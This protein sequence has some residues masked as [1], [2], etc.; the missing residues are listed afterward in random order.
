MMSAMSRR[1]WIILTF[2]LLLA[3]ASGFAWGFLTHSERVFP[4]PV[5]SAAWQGL[6]SQPAV[7]QALRPVQRGQPSAAEH[8]GRFR[9]PHADRSAPPKPGGRE[10]EMKELIALGYLEAYHPPRGRPSAAAGR[11]GVNLYSSGEA[12]VARLIDM[13]GAVLHTWQRPF[14]DAFPDLS[15]GHDSFFWRRV[16]LLPG[17]DLVATYRGRGVVRLDRDSNVVWANPMLVH[18]DLHVGGDGRLYA[19][20]RELRVVPAV[21][22]RREV[23]DDKVVILDLETGRAIDEISIYDAF[24][25][26]IYAP[27]LTLDWLPRG[28]LLHTNTIERLQPASPHPIPAFAAGNI[29]LTIRDI[30]T[31]AVLD[32]HR[33]QIVWALKGLWTG[34]H[35]A[36]LLDS[37]RLLIVDNL[38]DHETS[39][40]LEFDPSSQEVAWQF[41][42]RPDAPFFTG[43]LGD[44]QR[45]PDG[46]T[47]VSESDRGR[48]FEVDPAGQIVWEYETGARQGRDDGLIATLFEMTRLSADA[49]LSW[50]DPSAP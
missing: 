17:G 29:L 20:G 24:D 13:D 12:P 25:Q 15:E 9:S 2:A 33:R 37:G 23:I 42:G 8:Q 6:R 35:G 41:E 34:A 32:P 40:V 44:A 38:R 36:T 4:Y 49:D 28:E 43:A 14:E 31:V 10:L 30:D 3:G 47:L 50:L 21:H 39:A 22:E 18:H 27:L 11:D 19:I 48:A 1:G 45:L 5:V 26:S 46:N 16:R 7:D